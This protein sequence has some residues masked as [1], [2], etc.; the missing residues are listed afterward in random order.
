M[1]NLATNI[2]RLCEKAE[3]FSKTSIEL[4]KLNAVDKTSDVIASLAF[5]LSLSIIVAIFTFFVNI[6]IALVLGRYLEDYALGFF[7][8]SG[9]YLVFAIVLYKFR[10]P[11]IKTPIGNLVI[12]KLLRE[13]AIS[14]NETTDTNV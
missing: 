3:R 8:V 10:H 1:E 6:G 7:I 9:F 12:K 11:L 13:K 4:L 14:E 5:L 2:E